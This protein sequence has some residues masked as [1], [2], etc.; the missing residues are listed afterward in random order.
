[1]TLGNNYKKMLSIKLHTNT[2]KETAHDL[3]A[4]DC[5]K[6]SAS[7]PGSDILLWAVRLII[8]PGP[9]AV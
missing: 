4:L 2:N 7:P 3:R 9:P 8:V 5:F 1:M 6:H